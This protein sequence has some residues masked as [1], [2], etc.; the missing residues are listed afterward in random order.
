[1]SCKFVDK[2]CINCK[3]TDEY[4]VYSVDEPKNDFEAYK[5]YI[6]FDLQVCSNCGYI[7]LDIEQIANMAFNNIKNTKEYK[8][9]QEY[10]YLEEYLQ[11]IDSDRLY[12][13][14]A[15]L[16]ECYAML[17]E[18]SLNIDQSIRA[19]FRCVVL[20]EA[21]VRRYQKERE[22]DADELEPEEIK[23]YQDLENAITES[24][25]DNLVKILELY[26]KS[27]QDTFIKVIYIECLLR[28]FKVQDAQEVYNQVQNKIDNE[29]QEYIDNLIEQRR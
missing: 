5:N 4:M 9:A 26:Q 1:M 11:D 28:F 27:T 13:Y 7:S 25:K 23:S 15:N 12:S 29:L 20:K 6:D 16:Y 24:I 3:C 19:Y 22:D 18:N 8:N 14:P 17:Q 21:I 10:L 2:K